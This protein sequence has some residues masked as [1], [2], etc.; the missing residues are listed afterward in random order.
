[1]V[2]RGHPRTRADDVHMFHEVVCDAEDE[3]H[4]LA[5]NHCA[6]ATPQVP[7]RLRL[8]VPPM[9]CCRSCVFY[10]A[11]RADRRRCVLQDVWRVL[12]VLFDPEGYR[13]H[14]GTPRGLRPCPEFDGPV[15]LRAVTRMAG[16]AG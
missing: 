7:M 6:E 8:L 11:S 10:F 3:R 4:E 16:Q 12:D 14:E 13:F 15:P 5:P 1:M 2:A 9:G